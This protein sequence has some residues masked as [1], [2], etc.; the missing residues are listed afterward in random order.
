MPKEV[1]A[2]I[3]GATLSVTVLLVALAMLIVSPL[4]SR[5]LIP[6]IF[7]NN[8]GGDRNSSPVGPNKKGVLAA[9][10]QRDPAVQS[11]PRLVLEQSPSY[12]AVDGIPLGIEVDGKA[13]GMALEISEL[14]GGTTI[15]SG[16]ALGTGVWRILAADVGN[17]LIHLPPELSGSIDLFLEL[18]LVDDTVVDRRSLHLECPQRPTQTAEPISLAG[19]MVVSVPAGV[20][21]RSQSFVDKDAVT[22]TPMDRGAVLDAIVGNHDPIELLIG[23][24]EKLLSQGQVEA[25]RLLLLPGAKARHARAALALGATY[26]P[27]MLA[28]F[29]ARGVTA[30]VSIALDWYRKAS[31]F[32]SQKAQ[33]RLNLLTVASRHSKNTGGI[34]ASDNIIPKVMASPLARPKGHV[35]RAPT[36]QHRPYDHYGVDVA[37]ASTGPDPLLSPAF[38]Q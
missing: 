3:S 8:D 34:A 24:S 18:R 32:G 36:P 22:I 31:E 10:P 38:I 21:A 29:R 35:G 5:S 33:Q 7:A 20:K 11:E 23:R 25:A 1:A 13:D 27:I 4:I 16:R 9:K 19:T 14:P 37:G 2:A 17:A 6:L 15:S 12:V 30:D 28:I 26:D